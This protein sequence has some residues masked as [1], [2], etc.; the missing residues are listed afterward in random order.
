MKMWTG[1]AALLLLVGCA[2]GEDTGFPMSQQASEPCE[3]AHGIDAC[4]AGLFCAALDGRSQ[5]TCYPLYSRQNGES[6]DDDD[7]CIG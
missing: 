5:P 7:N 2:G 6:C 3:P 1:L 4:G